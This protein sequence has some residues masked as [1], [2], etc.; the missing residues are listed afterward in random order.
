MH[1][2]KTE[3]EPEKELCGFTKNA[4]VKIN[5]KLAGH[6]KSFF[7]AELDNADSITIKAD[8]GDLHQLEVNHQALLDSIK[9]R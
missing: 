2:F 8:L 3:C 1:H 7:D 9:S 5:G 4:V 6:F